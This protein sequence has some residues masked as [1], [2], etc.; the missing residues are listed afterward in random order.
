MND[1]DLEIRK[2]L[3]ELVKDWNKLS[4]SLLKG[5]I[6]KEGA[7]FWIN[8]KDIRSS[9]FVQKIKECVGGE[10][11]GLCVLEKIESGK[12][13]LPLRH[14]HLSFLYGEIFRKK[15]EE[16]NKSLLK[17]IQEIDEIVRE[18]SRLSIRS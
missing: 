7:Y 10:P 18:Y 16:Q 13:N 4:F 8:T 9:G 3:I 2:S 12:H 1:L 15:E 11:M 17:R 6:D 14:F 5:S